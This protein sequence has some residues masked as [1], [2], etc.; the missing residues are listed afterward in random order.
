MLLGTIL[1]EWPDKLVYRHPWGTKGN[2]RNFIMLIG[3][4]IQSYGLLNESPKH[5]NDDGN[6]KRN[7]AVGNRS[8]V[9]LDTRTANRPIHNSSPSASKTCLFMWAQRYMLQLQCSLCKK[10]IKWK[11]YAE[12][13]SLSSF[14]YFTSETI[15][16]I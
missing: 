9:L 11:Q 7:W 16:R 3:P 2:S 13:M 5:L 4:G 6:C 14:T 10:F 8:T 12:A 15:Q 1:M